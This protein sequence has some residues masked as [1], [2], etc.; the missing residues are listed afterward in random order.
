MSQ[1]WSEQRGL[2][3]VSVEDRFIGSEARSRDAPNRHA[4]ETVSGSSAQPIWS[5]ES[6][7][8]APGFAPDSE[9]LMMSIRFFL[10]TEVKGLLHGFALSYRGFGRPS[11]C[12]T[13]KSHFLPHPSGRNISQCAAEAAF[14]AGPSAGAQQRYNLCLLHLPARPVVWIGPLM[15]LWEQS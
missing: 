11:C 6:S 4:H 9:M 14:L 13:T 15:A 12:I 1:L 5:P 10:G 3:S 8:L 2:S 7:H